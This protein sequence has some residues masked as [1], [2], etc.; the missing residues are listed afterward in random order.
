VEQNWGRSPRWNS[1]RLTPTNQTQG[2]L[3]DR[4]EIDFALLLTASPLIAQA[5]EGRK[6]GYGAETCGHY[7]SAREGFRQGSAKDR[8]EVLMYLSWLDGFAT[9]MSAKQS[10]DVFK[11]K[12][13][14]AIAV[15]L[16][17]YCRENPLDSFLIASSETTHSMG[18]E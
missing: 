3:Y 5:A 17:T 13:F 14:D 1:L 10:K 18:K 6:Y 8:F 7:V 12:D 2:R 9:A 15:W 16:E 4:S 11:G